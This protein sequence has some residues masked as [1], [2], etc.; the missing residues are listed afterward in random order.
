MS[1]R[2]HLHNIWVV[3]VFF[4]QSLYSCH[5][6]WYL[7][8]LFGPYQFCPLLSP[9]LYECS[10]GISHFLE[11]IS[12]LTHSIV[13][14][15]F[16]ALITEEALLSLLVILWNSAFKWEY[17]SFSPL[18]F[19]SLLSPLF[20]SPPQAAILLFS[21]FFLGWSWSLSPV[22]CHEPPFIVHQA[23][24]LWDLVPYI[25]FSL[26]LYNCRGFDLI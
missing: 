22:Q 13:F 6:F 11:E 14:L 26:P 20:V 10:L 8:L 12:S 17:L 5:L 21:F 1:D 7:L 19:T 25:C 24:C 9:S 23:L 15:Y 3:K 2:S 18:L 16:F 4:V